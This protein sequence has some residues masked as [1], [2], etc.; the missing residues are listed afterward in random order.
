MDLSLPFA[1]AC[2][3]CMVQWYCNMPVHRVH[4][5][6]NTRVHGVLVSTGM[7]AVAQQPGIPGLYRYSEYTCTGTRVLH[8]YVRIVYRYHVLH[9]LQYS[10][11]VSILGTM[12]IRV[13]RYCRYHYFLFL[14]FFIAILQYCNTAVLECTGYCN[15]YIVL[16][17]V[18]P[19]GNIKQTLFYY[20][21]V[22][23]YLLRSIHVACYNNISI[24]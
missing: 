9:L 6:C 20:P 10:V 2:H 21:L 5:Y 19:R 17:T 14:L 1:M 23:P 18:A 16:Y 22:A 11:Q 3:A 13:P 7:P 15:M 24:L 12:A 4:V 8:V